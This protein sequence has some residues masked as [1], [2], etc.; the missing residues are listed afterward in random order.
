M[1]IS[2]WDGDEYSMS[3]FNKGLNQILADKQSYLSTR[4]K[5]EAAIKKLLD[6][7][8][9]C[10]YQISNARGIVTGSLPKELTKLLVKTQHGHVLDPS[11]GAMKTFLKAQK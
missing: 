3:S 1:M 2:T 10:E 11:Y 8:D 6:N 9:A 5:F 7:T 4:D